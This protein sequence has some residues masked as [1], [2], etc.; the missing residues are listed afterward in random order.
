[1]SLE[2]VVNDDQ[3]RRAGSGRVPTSQLYQPKHVGSK[4]LQE[5]RPVE[6]PLEL[7]HCRLEAVTGEAA[8]R[9]NY[10]E[11][12]VQSPPRIRSTSTP[13]RR[14]CIR[15]QKRW[16]DHIEI[17]R[18]RMRIERISSRVAQ[19]VIPLP[20]YTGTTGT[21]PSRLYVYSIY[22]CLQLLAC[23]ICHIPMGVCHLFVRY[24]S[25]PASLGAQRVLGS[26]L[27]QLLAARTVRESESGPGPGPA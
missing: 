23:H 14:A 24:F 16:S 4:T 26:S 11:R 15:M 21:I 19:C 2:C 1:M 27:S 3:A 10:P 18:E 20:P 6:Q 12:H 13:R 17:C 8:K 7:S 25:Y 5:G 9:E 22:Q